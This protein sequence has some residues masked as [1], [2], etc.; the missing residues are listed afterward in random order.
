MELEEALDMGRRSGPAG[1]QRICIW[2]ITNHATLRSLSLRQISYS[3]N[4][5]W[6]HALYFHLFKVYNF[7]HLN[8]FMTLQNTL[9]LSH[10]HADHFSDGMFKTLVWLVQGGVRWF[11]QKFLNSDI[12]VVWYMSGIKKATK[13]YTLYL[14]WN[15]I[16]FGTNLMTLKPTEKK[17]RFKH[18]L[19]NTCNIRLL[20]QMPRP[21]YVGY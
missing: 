6:Q 17:R 12:R 4:N 13:T 2:R 19:I 10:H 5:S 8:N 3:S 11:H 16:R 7:Y 14:F 9:W 20:W 18:H 15:N 21:S 1:W